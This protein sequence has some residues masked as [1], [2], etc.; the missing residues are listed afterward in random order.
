VSAEGVTRTLTPYEE[1]VLRAALSYVSDC[2]VH[3]VDLIPDGPTT[4]DVALLDEIHDL[5]MA[6]SC[7]IVVP[8]G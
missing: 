3:D 5:L 2:W 8:E 7:A 1:S 6:G 4:E